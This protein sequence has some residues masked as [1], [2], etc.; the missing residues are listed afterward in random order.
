MSVRLYYKSWW[1]NKRENQSAMNAVRKNLR[2]TI[3]NTYLTIK[4]RRSLDQMMG[5]SVSKGNIPLL[6]SQTQ[7]LKTPDRIK[8]GDDLLTSLLPLIPFPPN[9]LLIKLFSHGN[10]STRR[11]CINPSD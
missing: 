11:E 3:K 9:K 2:A 6:W 10:L 5:L 1:V 4:E 7:S 8:L